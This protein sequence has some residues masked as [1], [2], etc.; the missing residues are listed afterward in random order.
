MVGNESFVK[1]ARKKIVI[2]IY[3]RHDSGLVLVAPCAVLL[4]PVFLLL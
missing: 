1:R 4:C 3:R 2:G